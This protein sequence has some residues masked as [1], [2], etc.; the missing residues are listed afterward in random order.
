MK[1]ILIAGLFLHDRKQQ[2]DQK[3]D[4]PAAQH[5]RR[6]V[7]AE[8]HTRYSDQN[9][10]NSGQHA[11]GPVFAQKIQAPVYL[12]GIHGMPTRKRIA[13]RGNIIQICAFFDRPDTSDLWMVKIGPPTQRDIFDHGV[14]DQRDHET[15]SDVLCRFFV[16]AEVENA[17]DQ[18]VDNLFAKAGDDLRDL[19]PGSAKMRLQ[20]YHQ[21][22][23]PVKVKRISSHF[24]DSSFAPSGAGSRTLFTPDSVTASRIGTSVA[25]VTS[26]PVSCTS[27]AISTAFPS[28]LHRGR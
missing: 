16:Q 6:I 9:R 10:Q 17:K 13:L 11:Q 7:N 28:S 15:F 23:F 8:R 24:I 2:E 3:S 22:H 20:P 12:H 14:G 4:R 19:C 21:C 5:V 1:E 18:D 26:A 27:K 25:S